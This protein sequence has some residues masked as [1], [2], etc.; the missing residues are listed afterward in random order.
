MPALSRVLTRSV[1]ALLL[2]LSISG[3]KR[4]QIRVYTA[5]RDIAVPVAPDAAPEPSAPQVTWT[6]PANWKETTPG[7]MSLASFAVSDAAGQA[8]VNI[9]PLPNLAGR[10]DAVVNMW[11]E[12]V[13]LGPVAQEEVAKVFQPAEIAGAQG[14]T[15]EIGGTKDGQKVKTLVGTLHRG[16]K[17][18]F[19]KMSGD[20]AVVDAQR[21]NFLAFLKSVHIDDAAKAAAPAPAPA[22]SSVASAPGPSNS[23]FKWTVPPAWKTQNPG[24]MQVAKF[25]VPDKDGAKAEVS[26]SV[27]PNDTGGTLANVN[28]WR[29]QVGL[30]EVD[31]AGLKSCVSDLDAVPGGVLV[32]L[33]NEQR[34]M[35]GAIVPR[36]GK[37]WFYKLLGDAPAV[38]SAHQDFVD[39]VKTAP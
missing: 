23:S 13:G 16:D 29:R 6:L 1:T 17:S 38:V 8:T 10:E 12:Q 4:A 27:F 2:L 36:D 37:W 5:P 11:R 19:F 32:N 21:T 35:L 14:Q 24:Q 34:Q 18:W 3:C 28:R 9:T 33:T 39:F 25:T 20:E 26:V 31:E 22:A 15:F 30:P 7:Q